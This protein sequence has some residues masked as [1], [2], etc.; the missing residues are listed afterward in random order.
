MKI[1]ITGGSGNIAK[2][3][4]NNLISEPYEITN[5]SRTELFII[6]SKYLILYLDSTSFKP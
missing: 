5:L 6:K 1:L 4:K 2:M 3:I